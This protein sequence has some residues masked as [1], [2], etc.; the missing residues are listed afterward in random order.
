MAG[1]YSI[2]LIISAIIMF[3][4]ES[5]PS[6]FIQTVGETKYKVPREYTKIQNS[7]SGFR[8]DI[9][10]ETLIG[11]YER[12]RNNCDSQTILLSSEPIQTV[13]SFELSSFIAENNYFNLDEN[14]VT[15][16]AGAAK[17]QLNLNKDLK[18][19][20]IATDNFN[21]YHLQI[22]EQNELIR[23]VSCRQFQVSGNK[24]YHCVHW[25]NTPQGILQYNLVA[26]ADFN[27]ASWQKTEAKILNLISQWRIN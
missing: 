1:V 26:T 11:I 25:V 2:L 3:R 19:Y 16:L 21:K 6:H 7:E 22:N 4:I 10:I 8:I 15:A 12:G 13:A 27:L 5:V 17:Y 24:G 9:C 14:K 20:T 18:S 23:F